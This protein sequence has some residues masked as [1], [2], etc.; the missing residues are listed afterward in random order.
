MS[1]DIRTWQAVVSVVLVL[2]V[3][4]LMLITRASA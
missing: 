2:L 4:V 1:W 3:E